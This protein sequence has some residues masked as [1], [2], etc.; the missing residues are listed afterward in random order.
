MQAL[1]DSEA[2]YRQIA[3]RAG[4]DFAPGE[5]VIVER[6]QGNSN[7]AWGVPAV[8]APIESEPIEAETARRNV[9][10]LQAS[11][12]MLDEAVAGSSAELRKGPRGG[13]RE[14]DE[15]WQ[16]VVEA[17]RTYGRKIG[18]RHRPFKMD[19]ARALAA[20]RAEIIAVLSASTTG[21]PLT[22][23]G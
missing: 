10:L 4:L 9:A 2:R 14:R 15:V 23:G 1:R 20:M 13:G 11:W 21:E 8:L 7:T 19:D 3:Q 5:L 18:V 12:E 22:P 6:L 16:H 17:E